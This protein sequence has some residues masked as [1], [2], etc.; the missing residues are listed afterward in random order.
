MSKMQP[1]FFATSHCNF[2]FELVDEDES[3]VL[4]TLQQVVVAKLAEETREL[5]CW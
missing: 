1:T 2:S 3:V 5:F 4:A